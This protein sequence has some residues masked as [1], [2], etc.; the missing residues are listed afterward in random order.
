M[1]EFNC[2]VCQREGYWKNRVCF[3]R[4]R[5][6]AVHVPLF[7]RHIVLPG[8]Y[9]VHVLD[10]DSVLRLVGDV[11]RARSS[12]RA[13]VDRTPA[14]EVVWGLLRVCPSFYQFDAVT[15]NAI[16]IAGMLENGYDVGDFP[17][18]FVD[19]VQVASS[20]MA[21]YSVR[22][23]DDQKKRAEKHSRTKGIGRG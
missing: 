5:E 19:L 4:N 8:Q 18:D 15:Q 12:T 11:R 3:L 1:H 16:R 7:D 14:F 21:D 17:A 13:P 20:T 6:A 22:K 10:S 2:S 9:R 23:M